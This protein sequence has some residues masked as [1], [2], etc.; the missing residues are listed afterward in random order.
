MAIHIQDWGCS[1]TDKSRRPLRQSMISLS[2]KKIYFFD[3]V[4]LYHLNLKE[5]QMTINYKIKKDVAFESLIYLNESINKENIERIKFEVKS[6]V[7]KYSLKILGVPCEVH[8]E[9]E[10]GSIFAK[11]RVELLEIS[12]IVGI[13]T[14][15]ATNYNNVKDISTEIIRDS[16]DVI[17]KS[18]KNMDLLRNY[19]VCDFLYR[20]G[21]E[22]QDVEFCHLSNGVDDGLNEII[23]DIK[24]ART[25]ITQSP[26]HSIRDLKYI[27]GAI[28]DVIRQIDAANEHCEKIS[29]RKTFDTHIDLIEAEIKKIAITWKNLYQNKGINEKIFRTINDGLELEHVNMLIK[30][31][32]EL[33]SIWKE[34]KN[35]LILKRD[36]QEKIPSKKPRKPQK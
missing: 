29:N 3:R 35:N 23:Q 1:S 16:R 18:S 7:E 34:K 33:Q 11:I 20:S 6:I 26:P 17:T 21:A 15:I 5:Q 31:I 30:N 4:L 25:K 22:P 12:A 13:L 24:L 28:D 8:I 2:L 36:L 32:D 9:I 14:A 27:E 10:E 19:A